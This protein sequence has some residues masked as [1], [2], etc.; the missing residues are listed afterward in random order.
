MFKKI[1][2]VKHLEMEGIFFLGEVFLRH[3]WGFLFLTS[4]VML[5]A[6]PRSCS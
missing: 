4:C 1:N 2:G 3:D 5:H 6:V